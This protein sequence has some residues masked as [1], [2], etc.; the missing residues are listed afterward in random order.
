LRGGSL[1]LLLNL[2]ATGFLDPSLG[3]GGIVG[4]DSTVASRNGQTA[5]KGTLA[6][7]KPLLV[8][9]GASGAV[10]VIVDF[11][12]AYDQRRNS[13]LI[14]PSTVKIDNATARLKGTYISSG[15]ST[16]VDLSVAGSEMPAHDVFSG[17][18]G[19]RMSGTRGKLTR[20]GW[21]KEGE[22]R[23]AD[24]IIC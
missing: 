10:P 6:I 18:V 23:H 5:T 16:V 3:L 17:V 11:S 7:S 22:N 13:G 15:D 8:A 20:V 21:E 9:G 14:N 2:A 4:M 12:T 1:N 24:A 19:I